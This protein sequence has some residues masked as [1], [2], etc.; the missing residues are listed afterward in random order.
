MNNKTFRRMTRKRVFR[1]LRLF[2]QKYLTKQWLFSFLAKIHVVRE[3]K[4]SARTPYSEKN[5]T[6]KVN[7]LEEALTTNRGVFKLSYIATVEVHHIVHKF[8]NRSRTKTLYT[9]EDKHRYIVTIKSQAQCTDFLVRIDPFNE[10]QVNWKQ[11]TVSYIVAPKFYSP[12]GDTQID[13]VVYSKSL[14]CNFLNARFGVSMSLDFTRKEE[15]DSVIKELL[16]KAKMRLSNYLE[17]NAE[18]INEA[19]TGIKFDGA[20]H[21][22]D[23]KRL[24]PNCSCPR[25]GSPVFESSIEDYTAQCLFCDED[26]YSFEVKKIDPENYKYL[27]EFTKEKIHDILSE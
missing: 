12:F 21:T 23:G 5:L 4:Y 8:Q 22:K 16:G 17:G 25:C 24:L 20:F 10:I 19:I 2:K 6:D 3:M 27:Y 11:P 26:F 15:I 9:V 13:H 1:R 18:A 7:I 14:T